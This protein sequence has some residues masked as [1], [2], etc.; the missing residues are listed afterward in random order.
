[1]SLKV[2]RAAVLGSGV[3][4]AQIAAHLA[5]AGVRVHLLDLASSDPPKDPKQAA[6]VGKRFRSTRALLAV[7][8]LK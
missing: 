5:A 8:G 7:E 6:A 1:M 2:R 3:M 4:G